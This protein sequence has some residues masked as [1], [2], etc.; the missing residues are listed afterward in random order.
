METLGQIS[1]EI[2]IK[3]D[4][5]GQER[6]VHFHQALRAVGDA[7]IDLIRKIFATY[8]HELFGLADLEGWKQK[9]RPFGA[10]SPIPFEMALKDCRDTTVSEWKDRCKDHYG[11]NLDEASE[12]RA[13]AFHKAVQAGG[14]SE[15]ALIRVPL[16]IGDENLRVLFDRVGQNGTALS[17]ESSSTPYSSNPIRTFLILFKA[18]T[19]ASATSSRRR[20]SSLR[21]SDVHPS[22]PNRVYRLHPSKRSRGF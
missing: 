1:A 19:K 13:V 6:A 9:P 4:E 8:D 17:K 22:K 14:S 2:D 5:S 20:K 10:K 15:I 3:L 16:G 21:R 18:Y 11:L 7:D 12:K